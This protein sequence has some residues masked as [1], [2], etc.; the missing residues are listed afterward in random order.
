MMNLREAVYPV[1]TL[2]ML[3]IST[4]ALAEEKPI[5][6]L[7]PR[8]Q[9]PIVMD[10]KLDEWQGA[11][12]TPLNATHPDF[13][14]RATDIYYLWDDAALYV[15]VRAL[16]ANPTHISGE[17]ALYDGDAIEFYLDTRQGAD[18]GKQ[19]WAPGTLHA[20]FT[21]VTGHDIKPRFHVRDLPAFH[22][23]TLKGVEL[24]AARTPTGYTLEFKLPWSN[25]PN[26]VPKPGVPIGIDI[27]MGSADGGHR[28]HRTFAYSSPTSVGTPSTLGRVLLVDTIDT[29]ALSPYSRALFPFD[30]QVPGN[31]GRIYGTACLSPTISD[32]VTKVEARLLD[33]AGTVRKTAENAALSTVAD[34]WRM[35]RGE[36][37]TFDLPA[38]V[39]TL[40]LTARDA[41]NGVVA[42]RTRHVL[43]EP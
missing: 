32:A 26:I 3:F 14:N 24:A 34:H 38:G 4:L 19:D 33:A 12:V 40:V 1:L 6:G 20:F 5:V 22:D 18:L 15:G 16:D 31:Y 9:R 29:A 30:A 2:L 35:W 39:Y 28:V 10:G 23:L 8:A 42:E 41:Q 27:E 21:A 7:I 36:W 17:N 11:F 13:N 25:F 43:L 37:E